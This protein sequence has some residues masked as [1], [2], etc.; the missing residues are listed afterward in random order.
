MRLEGENYESIGIVSWGVEGCQVIPITIY[1]KDL[2]QNHSMT[3]DENKAGAPSVTQR[4]TSSL[5]WILENLQAEGSALCPRE[6]EPS[7]HCVT[8]AGFRFVPRLG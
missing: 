3:N 4:V 1:E 7:S 6:A 8:V 2:N 5:S